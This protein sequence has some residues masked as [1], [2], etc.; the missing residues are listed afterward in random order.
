MCTIGVYISISTSISIYLSLSLYIYIDIS[1][2]ISISLSIYTYIYIYIYIYIS[3]YLSIYLSVS[4][5]ICIYLYLSIYR[6]RCSTWT[7]RSSCPSS[8]PAPTT[9]R[10]AARSP[11][12][13]KGQMGSALMGSLQTSCFFLTEGLF[14]PISVDP[15]CPQPRHL[16]EHA[17][18]HEEGRG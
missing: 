9:R 14:A 16:E 2:S 18:L 8:P 13:K 7:A 3:L 1:I 15:I 5:S 6:R 12:F 17:G 11:A 10:R 4:I